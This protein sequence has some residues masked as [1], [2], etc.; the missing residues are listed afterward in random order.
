MHTPSKYTCR[1]SFPGNL[2]CPQL[3]GRKHS[4]LLLKYI[5]ILAGI[6]IDNCHFRAAQN[7]MK[8][9]HLKQ[10][11]EKAVL[12][13]HPWI[14]SGAIQKKDRGIADGEIVSICANA[15]DHLAYGYYNRH[16]QIAARILSFGD[17]K[18]DTDLLRELIRGA[19]EKRSDCTLLSETDARRLVFSEGD[20]FPGLIIDSYAGHLVMQCLTL[21]I[22]KM[23]DTIV[24]I[25]V[26]LMRPESI[27]ERSDHEGRILEGIPPYTGQIYGNTPNELIIREQ[28]MTFTVDV[29]EGQKTGF[30]LDQRNNRTIIKGLAGDRNVLNL[31]S[32][33]GGFSVAAAL[34]GARSVISVDASANALEAARKNMAMNDNAGTPAEFVK[35]DVFAFIRNW[36]GGSDLIIVDPPAFAKA[37][38]AVQNACRGYKELHLQIAAKCPKDTLVLTCSCSRFID[39]N[40]FQMI[41]FE[42]FA[43]T[44]RNACII[45]KYH[46]PCDHPV[47]IFCPETEYLKALL[48]R[49]E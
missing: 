30:Y 26:E 4:R 43:D 46:Q 22:E 17:R 37:R 12:R 24:R 1:S 40:L 49:V 13:R 42:A 28:D 32:Y 10:K 3:L 5:K 16:T 35:A 44:G 27:Y 7:I 31:F 18:V 36:A 41:I 47:N 21:G 38:N 2:P 14:F 9:I 34:G 11:K 23:K 20:Y 33:S 25:L 45:G 6:V 29:R 8:K 48:L 19:A 15:G 39:M